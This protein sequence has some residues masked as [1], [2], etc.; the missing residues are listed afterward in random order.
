MLSLVA[1][2]ASSVDPRWTPPRAAPPIL[3]RWAGSG[4]AHILALTSPPS[5]RT[6]VAGSDTPRRHRDRRA[7]LL[8]RRDLHFPYNLKIPARE[9]ALQRCGPHLVPNPGPCRSSLTGPGRQP[10]DVVSAQGIRLP[11]GGLSCSAHS[12]VCE[13]LSVLDTAD[14]PDRR[15]RPPHLHSPATGL[16]GLQPPLDLTYPLRAEC[17]CLLS[18]YRPIVSPSQGA[19]VLLGQ[20]R[21]HPSR[22]HSERPTS[23]G[24]RFAAPVQR[25]RP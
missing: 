21:R 25:G 19:G 20:G 7:T 15:L 16:D 11:R 8:A 1:A 3:A 13:D 5:M 10:G 2:L 4:L 14:R 23:L 18:H 17:G 6:C 24:D 12:S 22:S 9:L